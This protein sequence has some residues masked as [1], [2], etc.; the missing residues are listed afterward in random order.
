MVVGVVAYGYII[1]SVA[2]SLANADS[3]R[4]Q[5]QDKLKAINSYM[6]VSPASP[7]LRSGRVIEN[8]VNSAPY[9][10]CGYYSNT[11]YKDQPFS[12]R[13]FIQ[14]GDHSIDSIVTTVTTVGQRSTVKAVQRVQSTVRVRSEARSLHGQSTLRSTAK[15]QIWVGL[16]V[17]S[18]AKN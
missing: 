11:S 4:A 12:F 6:K 7:F 16:H 1:A 8:A 14:G 5:Y 18:K 9:L 17:R 13:P 2:A 15:R 3:A 10:P